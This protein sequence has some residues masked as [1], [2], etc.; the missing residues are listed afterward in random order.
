MKAFI[1]LLFLVLPILGIFSFGKGPFPG[2]DMFLAH[3]DIMKKDLGLSE[4]QVKKIEAIMG[5]HIKDM[6]MKRIAI[7]KEFLN[8]REELLKDNP[9]MNKIKSIIDKKASLEAEMEFTAI[10]RDM[11]IK[12]IL[13]KE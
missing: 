9:D 10:K 3:I 11:D 4:D 2:P 5:N 13:T 1:S 12:P 8:M 7:E 6:E